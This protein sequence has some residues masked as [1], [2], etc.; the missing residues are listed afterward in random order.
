MKTTINIIIMKNKNQREEQTFQL[1]NS[2]EVNA[3][4]YIKDRLK[5]LK[6]I[7]DE[8]VKFAAWRLENNP[9]LKN[10]IL[11]ETENWLKPRIGEGSIGPGIVAAGPLLI[12][13]LNEL[14]SIFKNE[15]Y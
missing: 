1:I 5:E 13:K 4:S 3:G 11:K 2:D 8:L 12:D 15:D 6:L 7:A 10:E 9:I 14:N